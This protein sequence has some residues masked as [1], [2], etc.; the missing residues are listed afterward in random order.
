MSYCSML[1]FIGF[2]K[3][4]NAHD[5]KCQFP[6]RGNINNITNNVGIIY[7]RTDD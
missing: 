2:N 4:C 7:N 5:N 6:G 3:S 1:F